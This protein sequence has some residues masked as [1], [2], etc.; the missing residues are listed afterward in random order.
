MIITYC[1]NVSSSPYQSGRIPVEYGFMP[2]EDVDV[3]AYAYVVVQDIGELRPFGCDAPSTLERLGVYGNPSMLVIDLSDGEAFIAVKTSDELAV[4]SSAREHVLHNA[5]IHAQIV[6]LEATQTP[7]RIR[8]AN[9]ANA[10]VS[11]AGKAWLDELEA[12]I[13]TLRSQML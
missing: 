13:A 2:Y 11:A 12:K 10:K 7:R 3:S 4:D 5:N 6:A 8:E 1:S 9:S